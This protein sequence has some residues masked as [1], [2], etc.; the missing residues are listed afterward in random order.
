MKNTFR[1]RRYHENKKV[2]DINVE[3]NNIYELIVKNAI[4]SGAKISSDGDDWTLDCANGD[5]IYVTRWES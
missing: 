2:K 3:T 4:K 5:V 1:V